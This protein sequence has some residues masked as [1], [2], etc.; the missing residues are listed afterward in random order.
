M[1]DHLSRVWGIP[2]PCLWSPSTTALLGIPF[3]LFEPLSCPLRAP[4]PPSPS[5]APARYT[6]RYPEPAKTPTTRLPNYCPFSPNVPS[7]LSPF[8]LS[9]HSFDYCC[10]CRGVEITFH[11][12]VRIGH[13]CDGLP[14]L[15]ST[16]QTP[17]GPLCTSRWCRP[18]RLQTRGPDLVFRL[19]QISSSSTSFPV[20]VVE[21]GIPSGRTLTTSRT[22]VLLQSG[23]VP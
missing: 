10:Y 5:C 9:F 13:F 14:A 16:Q 7:S 20:G 19:F 8:F 17:Y 2:I 11:I 23:S 22:Q 21:P 1:I 12:P 3:A 4:A 18:N 15:T 6:I